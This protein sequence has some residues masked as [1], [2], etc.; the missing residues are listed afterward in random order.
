MNKIKLMES[1]SIIEIKNMIE[2]LK[3]KSAGKTILRKEPNKFNYIRTN[4]ITPNQNNINISLNK[5]YILLKHLF[6]IIKNR[7]NKNRSIFEKLKLFIYNNRTCRNKRLSFELKK[8]IYLD[9]FKTNIQKEEYYNKCNII[10]QKEF[11]NNNFQNNKSFHNI[12]FKNYKQNALKNNSIS[13]KI[14]NKENESN[15]NWNNNI[16]IN[17]FLHK[18]KKSEKMKYNLSTIYKK[19]VN[20]QNGVNNDKKGLFYFSPNIKENFDYLEPLTPT[21]KKKNIDFKIAKTIKNNYKN[22]NN[23]FLSENLDDYQSETY[24]PINNFNIYSNYEVSHNIKT[25]QKIYKKNIANKYKNINSLNEINNSKFK[26]FI[27]NFKNNAQLQFNGLKKNLKKEFSEP[28]IRNKKQLYIIKQNKEN[29]NQNNKL[30]NNKYITYNNII[31][32]NEPKIIH[33]DIN[34]IKNFQN[35]SQGIETHIISFDKNNPKKNKNDYFKDYIIYNRPKSSSKFH[36]SKNK[37]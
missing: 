11:K 16:K 4:T 34:L 20:L 14:S 19:K 3:F 12:I 26:E 22:I 9:K 32:I 10:N 17:N 28:N 1:N 6:H 2:N 25:C 33:K 31:N 36:T 29:D 24:N 18:T 13:D 15:N 7:M 23:I 5:K 21:D 27:I 8:E 30:S 37:N 35:K